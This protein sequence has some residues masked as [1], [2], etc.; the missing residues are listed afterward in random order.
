M[1][2][3]IVFYIEVNIQTNRNV[4]NVGVIGTKNKKKDKKHGH[5][6]KILRNKTIIPRNQRI[7]HC[8]GLAIIHGMHHT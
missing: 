1:C 3:M 2:P 4:K 6:H 8:K 7:F 5:P